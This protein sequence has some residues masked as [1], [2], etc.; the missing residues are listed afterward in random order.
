MTEELEA[1]EKVTKSK[2]EFGVTFEQCSARVVG[3]YRAQY[4]FCG[5]LN[6]SFAVVVKLMYVSLNNTDQ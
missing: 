1:A 2:V 4:Y 3:L 6:I 5:L